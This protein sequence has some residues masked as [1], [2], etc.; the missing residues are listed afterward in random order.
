[1][2]AMLFMANAV[3]PASA[4]VAAGVG[5]AL[6]SQVLAKA[7]E[8]ADQEIAR[9]VDAM[10]AMKTR[11]GSMVRLSADEKSSLSSTLD[12]QIAA[13]ASLKTEIDAD[14]QST[15]SLKTDIQSI[16]KSYRIFMLVMPQAAI[17][18]AADRVM[19]I[20]GL[21]TTLAGKLQTRVDAATA[22]GK[23]MS[24]SVTALVDMNAKIADA[25]VQAQA[26]VSEMT[27]LKP[28]NGDQT[29][30]QSNV[31]ALKD[32]RAKVQ[33]AQADLKAARQDAGT[34]VKALIAAKIDASASSTFSA[35][36]TA[37]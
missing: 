33:A 28:D 8:R 34:V 9:R 1:M 23:D 30:M 22:A 2:A 37:Q 17:T 14:A 6:K 16:T 15:S 27:G 11:V 18:A 19:D 10:T 35:T 31:T 36:G 3:I 12:A 4:Q 29:V 7:M 32:A 25:T 21:M 13:M 24:T 26:A 5:A 20:A